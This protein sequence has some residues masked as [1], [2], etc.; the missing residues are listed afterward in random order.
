M[1][2]TTLDPTTALVLIDLQ[3]GIAGRPAAHP[4]AGVVAQA[5]RLASA[6]RVQGQPVV[7]VTVE[8]TAPGRTEARPEG[9]SVSLPAEGTGLLAELD[10]QP[11]DIRIVKRTWG[12]FTG[13]DL[14]QRLR[15]AGATEVVLAGIATSAGVEST[16]RHAHELGFHVAFATDAMTDSSAEAHAASIAHVFPR[17]GVIATTDDVLAALEATA[18]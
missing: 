11:G 13:T 14:E 9:G 8:A 5:A 15:E 16:A 2:L 3:T 17:I 12:A 10:A 1:P 7:L 18:A 6:F 4:V